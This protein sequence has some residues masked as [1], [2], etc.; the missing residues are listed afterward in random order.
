TDAGVHDSPWSVDVSWGDASS[1]DV[2]TMTSPGTLPQ[3]MHTY[4]D[5]GL[6]TVTV[7][8]TDK[9]GGVGT[10]SFTLTVVNQP[11]SVTAAANQSAVAGTAQSFDLGSFGDLGINDS[12]WTVTVTWGDSNSTTFTTNSRGALGAQSY[13]Y[14][15]AGTYSV[16]VTVTDK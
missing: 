2:F 5:N 16:R 1:H 12:P 6:Y 11:P 10:S 15:A 13:T 4:A 7:K 9:D 3:H 8:V 14:A